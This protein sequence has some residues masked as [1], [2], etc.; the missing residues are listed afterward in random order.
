VQHFPA[1]LDAL[2]ALGA[3]PGAW[4]AVHMPGMTPATRARLDAAGWT[5]M[6]DAMPVRDILA[7][8]G[9]VLHHGGTQLTTACLAAAIPQVLLPK[10]LDNEIAAHFLATQGLGLARHLAKADRN[11]LTDAVRRALGDEALRER[12]RLRA[13]LFRHWVASDPAEI[14]AARALKLMDG[15]GATSRSPRTPPSIPPA[16]DDPPAS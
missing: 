9:C 14:V 6:A 7:T 2:C 8:S 13:D 4:P 10:E 12:C 1:V 16:P 3:R 15:R 5:I 11:W